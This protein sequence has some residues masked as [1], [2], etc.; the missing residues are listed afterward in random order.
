MDQEHVEQ[1]HASPEIE[2]GV[3]GRS[4]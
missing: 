1:T 2:T 3:A 4:G